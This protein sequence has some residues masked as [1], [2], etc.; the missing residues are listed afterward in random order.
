MSEENDLAEPVSG[1]MDKDRDFF[2]Q[3]EAQP[4]RHFV[5]TG[6]LSHTG[7]G[8]FQDNGTSFTA[9]RELWYAVKGE[10]IPDD[11]CLI[12]TC[13]RT[14]C[15]NPDHLE[16][17]ARADLTRRFNAERW[18]PEQERWEASC[19]RDPETGCLTSVRGNGEIR[20]KGSVVSI[21]RTR[22]K[23]HHGVELSRNDVLFPTC[24]RKGCLEPTHMKR[25][26]RSELGCIIGNHW[27][28]EKQ[29]WD[30]KT[31][32]VP[33][34]NH[35]VYIP[36]HHSFFH[37]GRTVA[38]PRYAYEQHYGVELSRNEVLRPKCG[39]KD[40]IEPTHMDRKLRSE[41]ARCV[42]TE[43]SEASIRRDP[44]TGCLIA[45]KNTRVRRRNAYKEHCKVELSRNELVLPACGCDECIEPTH[46]KLDSL[47]ELTRRRN[48]ER[49]GR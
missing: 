26:S 4:G 7:R 28:D 19:Q 10:R 25:M 18:G 11:I 21:R 37:N 5:F 30:A 46:M 40:C 6:R 48:Y 2:S 22:Y 44:K 34:G 41:L 39:Y 8:I 33:E 42:N 14:D 49:S 38:P 13:G 45:V 3:W 35:L 17:I 23:Q 16:K 1:V 31:R 29:R 27:G 24:D 12:P 43:R 9:A 20:Q 47:N 32:R 36:N 15:G